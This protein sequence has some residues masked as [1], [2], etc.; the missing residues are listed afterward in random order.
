M[1]TVKYWKIGQV[2]AQLGLNPK[3]IR[4]YEEIR[5]I[6]PL[7]RTDVADLNSHGNRLFS[8]QDIRILEFIKRLKLLDLSLKQIKEISDLMDVGCCKAVRP[9]IRQLIRIKC[10]EV[11]KSIEDLKILK[12][13][14]ELVTE[15]ISRLSSDSEKKVDSCQGAASP[16][17]CAFGE[18]SI[19]VEIKKQKEAND[20]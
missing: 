19:K 3:T 16:C 15:K 6:P 13:E 9:Q 10:L 17:T 7:N 14:L 4:Y 12:A 11:D 8:E 1:S 2:A 5:L 18:E 20:E